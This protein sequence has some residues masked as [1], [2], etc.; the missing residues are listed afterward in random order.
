MQR[1]KEP[2]NHLHFGRSAIFFFFGQFGKNATKVTMYGNLV[3][4]YRKILLLSHFDRSLEISQSRVGHI[5]FVM[6]PNSGLRRLM[7]Q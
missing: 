6:P 1:R 5:L 7:V 4:I 2:L 3:K